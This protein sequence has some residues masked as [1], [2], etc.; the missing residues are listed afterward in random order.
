[1]IKKESNETKKNYNH[2]IDKK[3]EIMKNTE[4]RLEDIFGDIFSKVLFH[5]S[6]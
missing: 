1:M 5:Q 4:F 6:K 2:Y 3:N